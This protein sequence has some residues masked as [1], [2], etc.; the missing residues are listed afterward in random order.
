MFRQ[1]ILPLFTCFILVF[2]SFAPSSCGKKSDRKAK[3]KVFRYN[4]AEGLSSL[5]PAQAKNQA[6]TWAVSQLFNGLLEFDD[7]LKPVSS[8]AE[9]WTVS[10]DQKKYTFYLRKG[11]RFHDSEVFPDG[12]GREVKASDFEYSFKRII[13]PNTAS[14]GA[15]VFNDKVLRDKHGNFSDTCFKAVDD[16]TFA[17]YLDKPFPP[18]LEILCMPFAFV[19]PKEGIEK[20]AKD[21]RRNPIGT[22]P[23]RF[24]RWDEGNALLFEKNPDYWKKDEKGE[25]LPYIDGIK[26]SFIGDMQQT[27]RNF[28]AGNLDMLSVTEESVREQILQPDGKVKKDIEGKFNVVRIPYLST[29]YIGLQLDTKFYT[30]KHPLLDKRVR[31]ALS[32]SINRDELIGFL[33]SDLGVPGHAGIIPPM[34]MRGHQVKG[35]KFDI[36]RAHKLLHEA[37]YGKHFPEMILYVNPTY[38]DLAEFLQ[39]QWSNIGVKVTI[40]MNAFPTHIEMIDKG[41]AKIFR[42][43]WVADYPDPENY[44][45]LFYSRNFSPA[46]PNRT[47]FK[48]DEFDKLYEQSQQE[49]DEEKRYELYRQMDQIVVDEAPVIVLYYDALLRLSQKNI[50]D[51]PANAMDGLKVERVRM[52]D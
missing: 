5:D 4:Q 16:Y 12:K 30:G 44:L 10:E 31:Q 9:K 38:R 15:W 33:R 25:S 40:E 1:L 26:I 11:I 43:A 23:F 52:G 41:I 48:S 49:G 50:S 6:N 51:F 13:D 18:F 32:C 29:E 22:G 36:E 19:L 21:F 47:H 20:H 35:V 28:Y 45:V 14:P 37:G 39:K 8:L 42:S 46:G 34:L 24:K 2:T 17:I 3:L 27:Y 7:S